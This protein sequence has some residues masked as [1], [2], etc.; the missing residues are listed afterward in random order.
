ME[1]IG[2][3]IDF[4]TIPPPKVGCPVVDPNVL[5]GQELICYCA[6]RDNC[7][8]PRSVH[9]YWARMGS[10]RLCDFELAEASGNKVSGRSLREKVTEQVSEGSCG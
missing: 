9:R 6:N 1:E 3:L 4:A 7:V 10:K 5:C 2:A 8:Y